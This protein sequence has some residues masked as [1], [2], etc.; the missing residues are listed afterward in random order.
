MNGFMQNTGISVLNRF[1]QLLHFSYLV[2]N[3]LIQRLDQTQCNRMLYHML[4]WTLQ[5]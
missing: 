5:K 2:G 1:E 4:H 3:N